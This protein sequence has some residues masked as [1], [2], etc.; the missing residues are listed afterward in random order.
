[1][2]PLYVFGGL[3]VVGVVAFIFYKVKWG[4]AG[5]AEERSRSR[6]IEGERVEEADRAESRRRKEKS[7]E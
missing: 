7:K 2:T 1:M 5:R 4:R 6:K 3:I